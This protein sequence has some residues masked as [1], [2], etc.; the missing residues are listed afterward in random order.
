MKRLLV[1]ALLVAAYLA[2]GVSPVR[3]DGESFGATKWLERISESLRE[4]ARH[5]DREIRVVCECKS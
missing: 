4:I 5:S 3:A 1:P 2:G